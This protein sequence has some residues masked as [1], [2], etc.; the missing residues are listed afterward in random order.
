MSNDMV[1][2]VEY[3][4][5]PVGISGDPDTDGKVRCDGVVGKFFGYSQARNFRR[6]LLGAIAGGTLGEVYARSVVSV[7]AMPN[8][9]I[10]KE[11]SKEYW[12]SEDQLILLAGLVGTQVGDQV[13]A[14]IAEVYLFVKKNGMTTTVTAPSSFEAAEFLKQMNPILD[15]AF[16][17]LEYLESRNLMD[18]A[19]ASAHRTHLLMKYGG[20][21]LTKAPTVQYESVTPRDTIPL[22]SPLIENLKSPGDL[23]KTG[24]GFNSQVDRKGF[25]YA[26][27]LGDEF[28]VSADV[29][30]KLA[31]S[32]GIFQKITLNKNEYGFQYN[33]PHGVE[34]KTKE[35]WMY[36]EKSRSILS[37]LVAQFKA[38]YASRPTKKT[39]MQTIAAAVGKEWKDGQP[40]VE[41][42]VPAA[43]P[44]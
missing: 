2:F 44:N 15:K 4:S 25:Y 30:G 27:N 39:S 28:G 18:E 35:A 11:T 13:R 42:T 22:N 37:S 16:M 1:R 29:I 12:L 10:R 38:S 34:G 33:H 41:P 43:A 24:I 5:W 19:T 32:A 23:P 36:S 17:Q 40:L 20:I 31:R 21:D 3:K 26:H 9:G 6:F 7:H 14:H 8:G